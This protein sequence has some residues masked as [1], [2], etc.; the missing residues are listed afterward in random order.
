MAQT[1]ASTI[2]KARKAKGLTQAALASRAGLAER[3]LRDI[4]NGKTRNPSTGTVKSLAAVLGVSV[5]KLVKLAPG[6]AEASS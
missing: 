2:Q 5:A 6:A 3:S 4:E 1:L